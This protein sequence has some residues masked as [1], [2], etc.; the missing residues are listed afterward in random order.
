MKI[1]HCLI[2]GLLTCLTVLV[3]GQRSA[4][5]LSNTDNTKVIRCGTPQKIEELRKNDP[6]YDKRRALIEKQ[7]EEWIAKNPDFGSMKQNV[8]VTIPTVIHV[9]WRTSGG[10][11]SDARIQEQIDVLNEDYRRLNSDAS[12][13]PSAWQ[14]TAADCEIEFCL[15]TEDPSG[16]TTTGIERRQVTQSNIGS[17]NAYYQYSQGGLDIWNRNYYMNIWVCEIGGGTLGFAYLPGAPAQYDGIVIGFQYFG[18]TGASAPFN[19]GRTTT[20]EVSHWF[21]LTHIWGDD[22]GSCSGSDNVSD[23]PN[24]ADA[25]YFCP[26]YPQT[27]NCTM[28]SPGIMFMNY[29]DYSDDGCMNMFTSGQKTRMWSALNGTRASLKTSPGCAPSGPV[30]PVADFSASST[31]IVEGSCVNFTDLSSGPPTSWSWTFSGGTPSASTNQSPSSICFNSA[32]CYDVTLTVTNAQGNDSETKT[33][34]INVVP[35]GSLICD[36]FSNFLSTHT[37][38]LYGIPASACSNNGWGFASGHNCYDD[39]AKADFYTASNGD[40]ITQAIIY[41]GMAYPGSGSSSVNV[42]IW[43]GTTGTPGA[44]LGTENILITQISTSQPNFITFS[45][46]V[47]V[48][49][50]FFLG[51]EFSANGTPQDTIA[52]ITNA[53]GESTANTAWERWNDGSWYAYSDANS[54]GINLS[55]AIW[56]VRGTCPGTVCPAINISISSTNPTCGTNNGTIS[57]AGSGGTSPYTYNWST[58]GT[59]STITGLGSG[60]FLVTVTDANG[61]SGSSSQALVASNAPAVTLSLTNASSSTAC[62]GSATA[63]VAG[64]TSPYTY[65]WSGGGTTSTKTGLCAGNHTVTVTDANGCTATSTGTVSYPTFLGEQAGDSFLNLHPNP[66]SGKITIELALVKPSSLV[67]ITVYN[68]LGKP[69]LKNERTNFKRGVLTIDFTYLPRGVYFIE[70]N[71]GSEKIIRRFSVVN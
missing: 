53:D 10:N 8:V 34:Y 19:L 61:C 48:T 13:T 22:G 3:F 7:T 64:G 43:N 44:V 38:S 47:V 21:N 12:Q 49:G 52:I 46:P 31:T 50:N 4:V 29:Q 40:T 1:N 51:V 60:T 20:H 25:T 71:T 30:A 5:K 70:V 18:K 32:G 65:L 36:T 26:S 54:W 15:A 45:P 16:N 6:D 57:A 17:T 27:D 58:G 24:Q 56:V 2:T 28:G 62:D 66:T 69:V 59:T 37:P 23:T 67:N 39:R 42:R 35:A 68:V 55:H 63:N 14:T 41:F 33:C 11:L 9:L